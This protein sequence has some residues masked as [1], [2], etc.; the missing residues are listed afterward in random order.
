MPTQFCE[1]LLKNT[2]LPCLNLGWTGFKRIIECRK[3]YWNFGAD[4]ALSFYSKKSRRK[5]AKS[6]TTPTYVPYLANMQP[7]KDLLIDQ[8]LS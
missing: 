8:D 5:K 4:L 7:A 3:N 1:V 6:P 2:M